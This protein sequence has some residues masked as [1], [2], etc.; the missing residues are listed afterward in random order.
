MYFRSLRKLNFAAVG[1]TVLLI[2][3]ISVLS[4]LG[5]RKIVNQTS[6]DISALQEGTN[7][8]SALVSSVLSQIRAAEE[9]LTTRSPAVKV[10]FLTSGDSAY[11]YQ[12]QLRS[13]P[14]LDNLDRRLINQV[15]A[16]QAELEVSYATAH[17]L[18]DIG[19]QDEARLIAARAGTSTDSLVRLV[20]TL[21]DQQG[22]HALQRAA[23]LQSQA[24]TFQKLL[25]AGALLALATGV[26]AGVVLVRVVDRQMSRLTAAAERFGAGDLRPVQLN[27]MPEELERMARAMD[28]MASRLRGLVGSV[29]NE[30]QQ[31]SAS[32]GDFSAM[33]EEIAASSGE[34]SAAM[35]K[36]SGGAEHQVQGMT[37]ADALLVR[38]REASVTNA[39]AAQRAVRLAE[40]IR[41]TTL[42]YRADIETTRT[43]LLDVRSVVQTSS[44][45]VRSLVQRSD[46]ITAFIDLIKQI[47][48]QTNLLALNAAI[49]AA[50]AGEHGRGFAVVAEEVRQ[51][52]DSSARAAED[53]TKTVEFIRSQIR[54]VAETM[55]L[56]TTKVS[57]IETIAEVVVKGLDA[58][59]AEIGEVQNA[60][61]SLARQAETNREVVGELSGRT[62]LVSRAA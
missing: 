52:A 53:V 23:S 39:E 34:I 4:I 10:E 50:R 29:V 24:S 16:T 45:Q 2:F 44:Q 46:S 22:K 62:A 54:E 6:A 48:S 43:T 37:E 36:I 19:R 20:R 55:Q 13:L 18:V 30:A 59:G 38:L 8:G 32:A 5:L 35:V 41:R 27:D 61:T 1:S 25:I 28:D 40:E 47:S 31:L 11:V 49:E 15:A 57:G 3:A 60:A 33:S 56:G 12:A 17:A 26:G 21:S 58:I 14:H 9:Y 51:L 7:L 42:R